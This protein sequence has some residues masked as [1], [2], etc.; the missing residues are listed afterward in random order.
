MSIQTGTWAGH[1][2]Y[3]HG[4]HGQDRPQA[5]VLHELGNLLRPAPGPEDR[6]QV[7]QRCSKLA[8]VRC[9]GQ[10]AAGDEACSRAPAD[11]PQAYRS[12]IRSQD[13]VDIGTSQAAA[14]A[15]W[16]AACA[17]G[18]PTVADFVDGAGIGLA[19]VA[20]LVE[21]LLLKEVRHIGGR[22]REVVPS[23]LGLVLGREHSRVRTGLEAVHQLLAARL[24]RLR[25]LQAGEAGQ[26]QEA[27]ARKGLLAP[28]PACLVAGRLQ[29]PCAP[30]VLN[31]S[32]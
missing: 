14:A 4:L 31:S 7:V 10:Q 3:E 17:A 13:N 32:C 21:G 15:G 12:D 23:C 11:E 8:E 29:A 30:W 16:V 27:C 2:E 22:R 26:D 9:R 1:L 24:E 19:Q 6:V 20:L 28:L 18:V 5:Q 25:L